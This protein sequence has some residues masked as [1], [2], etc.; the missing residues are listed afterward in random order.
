MIW[1]PINYNNLF[2]IQV[3][4]MINVKTQFCSI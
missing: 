4:K 1:H 2:K 3:G